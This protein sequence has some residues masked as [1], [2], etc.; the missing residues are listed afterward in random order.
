MTVCVQ[1]SA[2]SF[3]AQAMFDGSFKTIALS[4]YQ[5][6]YLVLLFYPLDFTFVCPTELLAFDEALEDFR[7]V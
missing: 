4:D 2:P 7:K 6:K 5:G 3:S 1:Q